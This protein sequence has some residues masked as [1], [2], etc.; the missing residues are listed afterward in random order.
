MATVNKHVI[1]Y[2]PVQLC[3][4]YV[5]SPSG[6]SHV[7]VYFT[8]RPGITLGGWS[9]E[10]PPEHTGMP[11]DFPPDRKNYFIYYSYGTRPESPWSFWLDLQVGYHGNTEVGGV[12]GHVANPICYLS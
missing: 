12:Y 7:N 1:H 10:D 8:P 6:P 11:A 4:Y 9:L 2:Y 3:I 5:S